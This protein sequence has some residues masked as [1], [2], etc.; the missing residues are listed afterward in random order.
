MFA[1]KTDKQVIKDV[2]DELRFDPTVAA[3]RITVAAESGA[4]SLRGHV[5]T[6]ADRWH[7]KRAAKRVAGVSAVTEELQVDIAEADRR[8]DAELTDIV[9]RTLRCDVRVPAAVTASVHHAHITLH[10]DVAWNH[11]RDAAL[12]AVRFLRGVAGVTSEIKLEPKISAS[13]VKHKVQAALQRHARADI[14]NI[15]VET[16][17]GTVTLTGRASSWHAIEDAAA[18]A[19]AAGGVTNVIDAVT[20]RGS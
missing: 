3:E 4:V 10:G 19:W 13:E 2:E 20:M 7:A 16:S 11:D 17:G 9:T 1:D 12:R 6:H 18:A 8:T 15:R 5:S 14:N